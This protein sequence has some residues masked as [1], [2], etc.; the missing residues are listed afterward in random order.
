VNQLAAGQPSQM[1][2]DLILYAERPLRIRSLN[3]KRL[4]LDFENVE[5]LGMALD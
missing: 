2:E 3:P 4:R 1:F 5:E